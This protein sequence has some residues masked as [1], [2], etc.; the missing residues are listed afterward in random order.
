MHHVV[1]LNGN[2]PVKDT[3]APLGAQLH[4]EVALVLKDREAY[5]RAPGERLTLAD[6]VAGVCRIVDEKGLSSFHLLGYSA[7]AVVALALT[8]AHPERVKTLAVIEPPWSGNDTASAEAKALHEA[9]DYVLTKVPLSQRMAAFRQAIMR[10][11]ESPAPL[12]PGLLPAW[13]SLRAAQGALLWQ[14]IRA[15]TL[16]KERLK[17]FTAPVYVAVGTRSHPGFWATAEE[18][19][20]IFPRASLEVYDGAD[21]FAIHTQYVDRLAAALRTLWTQDQMSHRTG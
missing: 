19:V 11:G 6:E 8:A 1:C 12:P 7:G 14:A 15:A 13:A 5:S 10:P 20:S 17:R 16:E 4:G 18:V 9:L 3:F 21:H 2:A